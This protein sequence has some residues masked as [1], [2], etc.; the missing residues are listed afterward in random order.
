MT[1]HPPHLLVLTL[2]VIAMTG[3]GSKPLTT[4]GFLSDY[5]NLNK[6]SD[7][8][9][10][11]IGP[12]LSTYNAYIVDP[13]EMRIDREILKPEDRAD[14]AN[15]LRESFAKILTD[16]DYTVATR[17]GVGV[18]R[19]RMAIT[20]VQKS[21]WWMNL[22]PG[23]KL[24]GAGAGGAS[25]EGEVIDSVTGAQLAAVVQAGRGNQF[26]L[27]TFSEIDDVKDVIDQWAKTAG[28]RLDELRKR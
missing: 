16:R 18:A 22:H 27:D 6:I 21:T 23:T 26:E 9:M 17:P 15:Y 8:R 11:F 19:I 13:V 7:Q 10:N 24:T 25:M 1:H 14:V 3:C 12:E 2:I 20:D 5:S 28:E 4:S